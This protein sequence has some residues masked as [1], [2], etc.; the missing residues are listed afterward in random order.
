MIIQSNHGTGREPGVGIARF[1]VQGSVMALQ[2]FYDS[3]EDAAQG[4]EAV[5]FGVHIHDESEPYLFL[6][7]VFFFPK[8]GAG[9]E[10]FEVF[11]AV[12]VIV[13]SD[14]EETGEGGGAE[15]GSGFGSIVI[16]AEA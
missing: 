13:T 10:E 6:M 3:L 12:V 16:H 9:L 8:S 5:C 14:T 15:N 1:Q 4:A 7:L 2:E 11:D